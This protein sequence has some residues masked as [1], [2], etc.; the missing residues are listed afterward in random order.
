[1]YVAYT[2]EQEALRR[3]LRAYYEKLL[4]PEIREDLHRGRG[5][6]ATMRA[7]V[8]RMGGDGWLGIGWPKEYG[9]QGRGAIEQFIFFDESMRCGAP[10]PMLTIN[11]VGAEPDALRHRRAEALL[12]AEDPGGRAPLL[13]RLHGARRGHRSRGAHDPGRARRRRVR[14]RRPEGLHEPRQRRRLHLARRAH[15]P[16]RREARGHL[17]LRGRHGIA[18]ASASIPCTCSPTTTSTRCSSTTSGSRPI[19]WWAARTRAGS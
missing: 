1:M 3:E 8:R 5:T 15:G 7:V 11:T 10:V 13:H 16:D 19:G 14:D 6:G 4:T 18:R 12:P 9:G 17:D 2:A